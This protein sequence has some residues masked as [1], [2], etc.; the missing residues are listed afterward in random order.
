M[1]KISI[2]VESTQLENAVAHLRADEQVRL[3][4]WLTARHLSEVVTKLRRT[5]KRK[6]LSSQA[7]ERIVEQAREE[8]AHRRRH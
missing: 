6:G 5:V 8:V 3:A 4:K 2:E 1:S 7:I